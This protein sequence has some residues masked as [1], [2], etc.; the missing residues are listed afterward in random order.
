MTNGHRFDGFC[1]HFMDKVLRLARDGK[2]DSSL[3]EYRLTDG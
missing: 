2:Y 1:A 3:L